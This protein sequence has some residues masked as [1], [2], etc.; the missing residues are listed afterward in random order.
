M[1][2]K[3]SHMAKEAMN[4]EK[5]PGP[6]SHASTGLA[7]YTKFKPLKACRVDETVA[8]LPVHLIIENI[9]PRLP[10][11]SL[12]RFKSVCKNWHS[13]ISSPEF[14][15]S[16][17]AFSGCRHQFLLLVIKDYALV[18]G[19]NYRIFRRS[20]GYDD[21]HS[22][23]TIIGS[24]NGL[25][26]FRAFVLDVFTKFFVLNPATG[27][28]VEILRPDDKEFESSP[29]CYWFG[30]VSSVDDYKIC[31]FNA[32]DGAF[33]IFSLK[34]RMWKRITCCLPVSL[35]RLAWPRVPALVDDSLY[36]P[37]DMIYIGG[38]NVGTDI[39]E[40]NLVS[41]EYDVKPRLHVA[42]GDVEVN[43]IYLKGCLVLYTT[44][45]DVWILRQIGDWNSWEKVFSRA[46]KDVQLLYLS[47]TDK[48]VV[49]FLK[50]GSHPSRCWMVKV[51][52]NISQLGTVT[53]S[54]DL[55]EFPLFLLY[56]YGA[57]G[58]LADYAESL[59]SPV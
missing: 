39:I 23:L 14:A 9:L 54:D 48:L 2:E 55:E 20:L 26:G 3:P 41:E 36:W 53:V 35:V 24:S 51:V 50:E 8:T 29:T 43:L 5:I 13:T 21:R 40:L 30:Y 59:I 27:H 22:E 12:L 11:K 47:T 56:N 34:A 33:W 7:C 58:T 17:L 6:S 44:H 45:L 18:E 38:Y 1:F 49:S 19:P 46:D 15:N 37:V 4:K 28:R 52:D 16:H 42:Y 57:P 10:V 32:C 31:A 25:V